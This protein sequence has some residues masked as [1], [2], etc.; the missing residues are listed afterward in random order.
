MICLAIPIDKMVKDGQ[1]DVDLI[2]RS[3]SV[4]V[5]VILTFYLNTMILTLKWKCCKHRRA[6]GQCPYTEYPKI[7][8]IFFEITFNINGSGLRNTGQWLYS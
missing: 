8:K 7:D 1:E 5:C 2:C 3:A 6:S 4:S